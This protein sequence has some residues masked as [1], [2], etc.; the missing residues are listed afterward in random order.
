MEN[1]DKWYTRAW[2]W[3]RKYI[4]NKES[5]I[6][7]LVAEAVFW[8]PVWVPALIA[9]IT[10]NG[11]YWTVSVAVIVFWCGPFTPAIPIQIAFIT[12]ATALWNKFKEKR[13]NRCDKERS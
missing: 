2:R 13:R 7:A 4:F 8:T 9:I 5:V 10:G 1:K 6:P 12:G 11:W 3:L